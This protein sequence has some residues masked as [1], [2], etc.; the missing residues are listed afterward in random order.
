VINGIA[1]VDESAVTGESAPVIRAAGGDRC[2]VT[3]GTRILS[4]WL[5]VRVIARPGE[6]FPDRMISLIEG[7][8]RQKTPNVI[9]LSG[10]AV[11]AAGDVDVLL[12]DK[13]GTITLGNRQAVAFIPVQ[14]VE[15]SGLAE[16]AQL[17]SL[18][19]KTPEGRSV[20]VLAKEKF[21]LRCRSVGLADPVEGTQMEHQSGWHFIPTSAQTRMSGVDIQVDGRVTRIR[22]G[23]PDTMIALIE[24][25]GRQV[26][27]DLH[28]IVEEIAHTGGTPLVVARNDQALGVVHLKDIVKGG[29]KERFI[30][31][32]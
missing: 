25:A 20:V 32:R 19:V 14:G 3:G 29:I 16:S 7:A 22:K 12:L 26:P 24:S 13:T 18:A 31:L 8:K 1:A 27:A 21:G 4:D 30:H 5:V 6:G 28:L 9:A 11:E 15:A 10:R 17:A 2:A 23:A